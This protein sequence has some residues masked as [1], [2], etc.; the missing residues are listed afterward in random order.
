VKY[1][2]APLNMLPLTETILCGGSGRGE[3]EMWSVVWG[4]VKDDGS[5]S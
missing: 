5:K 4:N 2:G 1:K 3:E